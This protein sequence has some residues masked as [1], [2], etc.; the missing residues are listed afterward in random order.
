MDLPCLKG[1]ELKKW[2]NMTNIINKRVSNALFAI[3]ALGLVI[4]CSSTPGKAESTSGAKSEVKGRVAIFDFEVRGG[5][6]AYASL[7]D[8][9]PD[10]LSEALLKGGILAPLE[11][12]DLE[13]ALAEQELSLSGIVDDATAARVGRL[14]GARYALLGSAAI[15]GDQM[16]L[17]CRLIDIE[18]AEILY[19]ESVHGD[20]DKPFR[21]V[22]KL[23][24]E[25][26][27][28]FSK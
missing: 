5:D 1:H 20:A 3:A 25:V 14:A 18:T 7:C 15:L 9:I 8:D 4:S 24:D 21:L 2:W 17:S 28:G 13:K 10:S 11:R 26:Q 27:K 16:R 22:D 19:A 6:G 12:R 23:A